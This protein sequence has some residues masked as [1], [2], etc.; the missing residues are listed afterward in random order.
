MERRRHWWNGSWGRLG[1]RDIYLYEDG[2]QWWVEARTGGAEG[3]SRW[4]EHA[5]QDS[6]DDRV[7]GLLTEPG[8]WREVG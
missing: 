5:D 4:F 1:R 7:R 8:R 2:G 3:R 6:A